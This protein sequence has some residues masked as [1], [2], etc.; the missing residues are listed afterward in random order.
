MIQGLLRARTGNYQIRRLAA[1]N[2]VGGE[3]ARPAS[4]GLAMALGKEKWKGASYEKRS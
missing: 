3:A 4:G 2:L 1:L